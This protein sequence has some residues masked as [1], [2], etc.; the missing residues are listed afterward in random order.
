MEYPSYGIYAE[1]G[2]CSDGKIKEDAEYMY[3]YVKQETGLED[4]DIMIF[5]RSIGT[6]P[7]CH[8]AGKH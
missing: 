2:G 8:L 1:E 4:K 3:Q 7:A 6:G 5:G